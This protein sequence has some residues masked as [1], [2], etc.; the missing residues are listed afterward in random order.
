MCVCV[1]FN[2]RIFP[3]NLRLETGLSQAVHS[4]KKEGILDR[5]FLL[6][7]VCLCIYVC[8]CVSQ[9]DCYDYN[10][11]GSHDFIGTFQ[12]TLAQIQQ[13]S[14]TYAVS[15]VCVCVF[16]FLCVCIKRYNRSVL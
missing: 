1:C 6:L 15:C 13:A 3:V 8:V 2:I 12:T 4:L 14:Q 5:L 9:V 11:S 7:T 16:A 10:N